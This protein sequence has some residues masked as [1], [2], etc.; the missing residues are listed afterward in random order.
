MCKINI[1]IGNKFN[2]IYQGINLGN[3]LVGF[4]KEEKTLP[5]YPMIEKKIKWWNLFIKTIQKLENSMQSNPNFKLIVSQVFKTILVVISELGNSKPEG[6]SSR[7][8]KDKATRLQKC[9]VK[10]S[11]PM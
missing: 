5:G 11:N 1:V 6:I 7:G 2:I 3:I 10:A 4:F 9:H 8:K